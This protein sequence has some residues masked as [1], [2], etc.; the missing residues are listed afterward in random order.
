MALFRIVYKLIAMII[1]TFI[2][3]IM[4]VP[5]R[6][7]G[8]RGLKGNAAVT[9]LW[10]RGASW[11]TNLKVKVH[12]RR[13]RAGALLVSNHLSYVDGVAEGG[14]VELRWAT[15]SDIARWPV[16]GPVVA[17]SG[18]MWVDRTTKSAAKRTLEEFKLTLE[19]G[20]C[21]LVW[22]EGTST[23]GKNGV[24]PFKSTAFEASVA[25]GF[26]IYPLLIKYKEPEVAWY[27]DMYF[28]PHF[29]KVLS[30]AR[31]TADVYIL[32]AIFPENRSRKE[33]AEHVR[34]IMDRRYRDITKDQTV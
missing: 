34:E 21:L 16:I 27:A 17:S 9:R 30:L 3:V 20:L 6:L 24:L 32:D 5:F 15:R 25:T 28:V 1:W 11:I 10:I 13:P 2:A 14:L 18:T 4:T 26:P 8:K 23:D 7:T 33:L 29:I 31:M 12:G 19:S 22:P